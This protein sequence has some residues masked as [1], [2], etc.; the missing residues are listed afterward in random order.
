MTISD[1]LFDSLVDRNY[2]RNKEWQGLI[3]SIQYFEAQW[4]DFYAGFPFQELYAI[5]RSRDVEHLKLIRKRLDHP[6]G[7]WED[8]DFL[9]PPRR[10]ARLAAVRAERA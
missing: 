6:D 3:E 4:P 2:H 5:I 7:S 8:P 1:A 10:S 9:K